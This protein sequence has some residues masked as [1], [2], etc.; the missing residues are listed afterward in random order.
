MAE[1]ITEKGVAVVDMDGNKK[2]IEADTVVLAAGFRSN[3]GQAEELKGA[4]PELY[5]IGDCAKL[6]KIKG[7]IHSGARVAHRI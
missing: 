1:E 6:G 2:V 7:A 3:N 5:T 4:V